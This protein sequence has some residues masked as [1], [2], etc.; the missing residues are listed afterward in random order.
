MQFRLIL[1][2]L[3]C[4][5]AWMNLVQAAAVFVNNCRCVHWSKTQVPYTQ[6]KEYTIQKEGQCP[7]N[8]VVFQTVQG[9]T[10]C[11]DPNSNWAKHVIQKLEAKTTSSPEK[12]R[13]SKRSTLGSTPLL[14]TKLCG[15]ITKS[16][17]SKKER[18]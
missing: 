15:A 7:N 10:I 1:T 2:A 17:K 14:S 11:K 6:I 3:L 18:K 13:H 9:K 8:A 4:F 16:R 5:T 12:R